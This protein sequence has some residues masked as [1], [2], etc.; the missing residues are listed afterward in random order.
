MYVLN[1]ILVIII[2]NYCYFHIQ[3]YLFKFTRKLVLILSIIQLK[4]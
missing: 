1:Q 4:F 3:F 2:W